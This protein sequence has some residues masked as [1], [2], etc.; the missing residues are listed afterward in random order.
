MVHR[1]I[2]YCHHL[3]RAIQSSYPRW[4]A[5]LASPLLETKKTLQYPCSRL[6]GTWGSNVMDPHWCYWGTDRSIEECLKVRK[7]FFLMTTFFLTGVEKNSWFWTEKFVQVDENPP[8]L[9]WSCRW[10]SPQKLIFGYVLMGWSS[11]D[12]RC[13]NMLRMTLKMPMKSDF[14]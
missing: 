14:Y 12:F 9:L 11:R 7:L 8:T 4:G 13:L 3:P 5:S 10:K 2:S 6:A 1:P